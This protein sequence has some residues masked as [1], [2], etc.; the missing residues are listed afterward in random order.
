MQPKPVLPPL[1]TGSHLHFPPVHQSFLSAQPHNQPFPEP[2]WVPVALACSTHQ[3][4]HQ[5][6][7]APFATWK[8]PNLWS[9]CVRPG[10]GEDGGSFVPFCIPSYRKASSHFHSRT[11]AVITAKMVSGVLTGRHGTW[12]GVLDS[13]GYPGIY[14]S[15]GEDIPPSLPLCPVALKRRFYS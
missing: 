2:T 6:V 10:R 14:P 11:L 15:T 3:A 12:G 5:P 1:A 9:C 7:K 8:S 4:P 13:P